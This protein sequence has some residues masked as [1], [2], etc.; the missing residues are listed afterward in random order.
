MFCRHSTLIIVSVLAVAALGCENPFAQS[1][2]ADLAWLVVEDAVISPGFS[3][4]VISYSATVSPQ[5]A[6]V[7]VRAATAHRDARIISGVGRHGLAFGENV[8]HV[9]VEAEDGTTRIYTVV[10]ERLLEQA[11]ERTF[12]A[13]TAT[14]GTWYDV[15]STLRGIASRVLVYVENTQSVSD[16]LAQQIAEE[17]EEAIYDMVEENFGDVPDVDGNG[18]VI[19]LLLD[20]IDGFTG[21]G[22]YVA[23]Y[24][25]PVHMFSKSTF[26]ESNEADMLF[27]DVN[28]G[29]PGSQA[30]YRTA[31][32]ELQHLVNFGNTVMVD[33]RA[34]DLW[35]NEGLSAGAEYLYESSQVTS[36]IN[37]HNVDPLETIRLGNSFFVWNGYWEQVVGDTLANYS[38]VYLFF[39]WLQL[40]ASNGTGIYRDILGSTHRDYRTVVDAASTRI[41]SS[42]SSWEAVISTWRHANIFNESSGLRGY[43]GEI[44][45]TRWGFLNTGGL[46]WPTSPGEA[47]LIQTSGGQ[48]TYPGGSGSS[49]RYHGINTAT[50]TVDTTGPTYSGDSVLV[51][52]ANSNNSGADE[53]A[54]LPSTSS[55][56][57]N[58]L[59]LATN[60]QEV[61]LPAIYPVDVHFNA[62]HGFSPESTRYVDGENAVGD[63]IAN[64]G[65]R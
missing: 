16:S 24:F 54:I 40:H 51:F 27:M 14:D 12:R 64:R 28:P 36:R 29:V 61:P 22:G 57:S 5:T 46:E 35:I 8:I 63:A 9:T 42:L 53:I 55:A 13:R 44:A 38:T 37:Y 4:E 34:Q 18:K 23:G 48:Y 47:L 41:S 21:S 39:Q 56:E 6:E 60:Y 50:N 20:I 10:I 7:T 25:D 17:F 49:I 62:G 52:N 19:L 31:A 32:H 45:T 1:S 65:R 59:I 3:P 33:G 11:I 26:A 30:F 58:E 43:K 2:D 15:P